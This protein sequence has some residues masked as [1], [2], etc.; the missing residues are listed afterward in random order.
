M[1]VAEK[2]VI[3][4]ARGYKFN[5]ADK[6]SSPI[7]PIKQRNNS[8][9]SS[10]GRSM[11]ASSDASYK[12]ADFNIHK[13]RILLDDLFKVHYKDAKDWE[14]NPHAETEVSY[15]ERWVRGQNAIKSNL[16]Q[17]FSILD[18]NFQNRL[19][20]QKLNFVTQQPLEHEKVHVGSKNINDRSGM[21]TDYSTND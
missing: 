5:H 19:S 1:E 11:S 8:A 14:F 17:Y 12:P 16:I 6:R 7:R 21:Q 3:E 15:Q 9:N 2:K 20:S 18:K 10:I 4:M 13:F